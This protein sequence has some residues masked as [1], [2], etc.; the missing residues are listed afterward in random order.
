M[1]EMS[2]INQCHS[3]YMRILFL[4]LFSFVFNGVVLGSTEQRVV[5]IFTTQQPY[6]ATKPWLRASPKEVSG[7]GFVYKSGYVLTSAHVVRNAR[8]LYLQPYQSSL[9][10]ESVVVFYASGVDLAVI[11]PKDGALADFEEVDIDSSIP[12]VTE[13]VNIFGYPKGGNELSIT[14]GVISRIEFVAYNEG[15]YGLRLQVDAAVNSG[16]S[17]GPAFVGDRFIGIVNSKVKE[18]DNI[19]YVIPAEEIAMFLTDVEDG[20]YDGKLS[21]PYSFSNTQNANLRSLYEL[22]SNMGGQLVT[23]VTDFNV[24]DAGLMKFDILL[25]I[26]DHSIDR[27]GKVKIDGDLQLNLRYLIPKLSKNGYLPVTLLREKQMV[28]KNIRLSSDQ[29]LLLPY[30]GQNPPAYFIY[31]PLTFSRASQDFVNTMP[32]ELKEKLRS[33][34]SEVLYRSGE[35]RLRQGEELVI[36]PT[37]MFVHTMT[38][39]MTNPTYSVLKR[40]N[41]T[42]ILNLKQLVELLNQLKGDDYATFEFSYLKH[43][44]NLVTVL[45]HGEVIG[46]IDDILS[47]NGIRNAYSKEF[48]D[49]WTAY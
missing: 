24:G 45:N 18:A 22:K 5:K 34:G 27:L 15:S 37:G 33:V 42:E 41:G 7:T 14:E 30:L 8:R 20:I 47:D 17:G 25:K 16:N 35:Y 32:T 21:L 40:L 11:R 1:A 19:G 43:S 3:L 48:S 12:K 4:L 13:T 2:Q 9:K 49:L 46:A 29:N 31:G 10:I 28:E 6:S 36:C 39:G 23:A 26:G 44:L 38:K